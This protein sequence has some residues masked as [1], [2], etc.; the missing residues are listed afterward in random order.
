MRAK[1]LLCLVLGGL[2]PGCG[3]VPCFRGVLHLET[4]SAPE[5]SAPGARQASPQQTNSVETMSGH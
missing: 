2:L 3:S 1:L 5:S 4:C